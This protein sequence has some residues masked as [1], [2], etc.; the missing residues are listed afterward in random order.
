MGEAIMMVGGNTGESQGFSPA[1]LGSHIGNEGSVGTGV[2][3]YADA[4]KPPGYKEQRYR[5]RHR[6]P[7][8]GENEH[9]C[10]DQKCDPA[11][12]RIGQPSHVGSKGDGRHGKNSAGQAH[13]GRP[14]SQMLYVQRHRRDEE[15]CAGEE[16]ERGQE[17]QVEADLPR[18]RIVAIKPPTF[19]LS[20]PQARNQGHSFSVHAT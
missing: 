12:P 20:Y 16:Q 9:P 10:A 7:Q 18:F 13:L 19:S 15:V 14:S 2:G 11:A 1:R 8:R 3:R 6:I 4:L 5:M 17:G